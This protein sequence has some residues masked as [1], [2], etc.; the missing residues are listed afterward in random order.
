MN[1]VC[2]GKLIL[3][4]YIDDDVSSAEKAA[5]EKHIASCENSQKIVREYETIRDM[6]LESAS[7][8]TDG[9]VQISP[10]PNYAK[11]RS[12][13][14]LNPMVKAAALIFFVGISAA[15]L[16]AIRHSLEKEILVAVTEFS[17]HH[18]TT[19]LSALVYYTSDEPKRSTRIPVS[20]ASLKPLSSL[21][22]SSSSVR[23]SYQSPLFGDD[24]SAYGY[25]IGN[26]SD[27]SMTLAEANEP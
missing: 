27:T 26:G 14:S 7:V 4:R 17:P 3:S 6:M 20:G 23:V 9:H 25:S 12:R 18:F 10:Y 13:N 2:P 11:L 8:A 16:F 5:I 21:P 15:T 22:T 1:S 19:P 24:G